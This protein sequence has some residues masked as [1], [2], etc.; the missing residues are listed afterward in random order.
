MKKRFLLFAVMIISVLALFAISA[1]AADI[2]EWTDI[3]T[4]DG[5]PDKATFGDDGRAGATSR[6][7]MADGVTYPAYY[8]CKN[9]ASLS[10]DLSTLNTKA[11]KSYGKADIIKIETI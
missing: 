8:I 10:L 9:Q 4:V 3:T 6:V 7:L 2:P 5:M 1:S 11:S